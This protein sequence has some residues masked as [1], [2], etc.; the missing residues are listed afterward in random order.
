MHLFTGLRTKWA[1]RIIE[2]QMCKAVKT[3]FIFPEGSVCIHEQAL[4]D[5]EAKHYIEHEFELLICSVDAYYLS[6]DERDQL[7]WNDG[8]RYE[9]TPHIQQGCFQI[10]F[11]WWKQTHELPFYGHINYWK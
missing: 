9:A 8:F 4:T 6:E 1:K 7:A 3:I 5:L 10:M 11:R 2:P